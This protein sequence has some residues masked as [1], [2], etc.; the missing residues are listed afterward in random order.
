MLWLMLSV[1]HTGCQE[2]ATGMQ[3]CQDLKPSVWMKNEERDRDAC[4]V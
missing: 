3:A 2:L 4:A 1:C